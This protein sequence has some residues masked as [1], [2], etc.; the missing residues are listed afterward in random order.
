MIFPVIMR[1]MF[2]LNWKK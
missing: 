2:I 1:D